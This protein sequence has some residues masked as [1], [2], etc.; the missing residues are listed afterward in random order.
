M[1]Y[2]FTSLF[3][4]GALLLLNGC[5]DILVGRVEEPAYTLVTTPA[6][7]ADHDIEIRDYPALLVAETRFTGDRDAK[8]GEAFRVLADYIFGNN[9]PQ[10]KIPMTAPVLE[11]TASVEASG[12]GQTIPMTA[13][14]TEYKVKDTW[15]MGFVMPADVSL[16]SLPQPKTE[17]ITFRSIP[18]K[19]YAVIRFSGYGGDEDITTHENLLRDYLARNKL[20]SAGK[21]ILAFYNP[22][23]TMPWW[24]R[25]EVM[26]EISRGE[27]K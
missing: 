6:V 5:T 19:R 10:Q 17:A 27:K 20:R 1:S 23:W 13:P 12:K 14:V 7:E 21:P 24:R 4:V 15:V 11:T 9:T 25:N 8:D 22:P 26:L 16:A 3:L 18:P 2:R